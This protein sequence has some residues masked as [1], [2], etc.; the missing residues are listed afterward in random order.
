V[1][2]GVEDPDEQDL[3]PGIVGVDA[4]GQVAD[5][6]RDVRRRTTTRSDT[7]ALPGRARR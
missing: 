3:V 7:G 6:A 2:E 5:L 1:V 4:R